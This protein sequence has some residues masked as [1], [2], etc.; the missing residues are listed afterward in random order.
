M[1]V[2]NPKRGKGKYLA[3][4][5]RK[6][7]Y[8]YFIKNYPTL[9]SKVPEKLY[10][11]ILDEYVKIS[12]EQVLNGKVLDT[13][14][15]RFFVQKMKMP[16]SFLKNNEHLKIDFKKSM[17]LKKHVFFTND[18]TNNFRMQITWKRPYLFKKHL[19]SFQA[20]R[21]FKRGITK[22][23]KEQKSADFII[24]FIKKYQS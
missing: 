11:T 8:A 17:E 15:G 19:Y 13:C 23:L 12:K 3:Q 16:I 14:I 10:Y 5:K 2:K 21:D 1:W 4:V 7:I 20:V 6:D 18:H 9:E 22:K 24:K